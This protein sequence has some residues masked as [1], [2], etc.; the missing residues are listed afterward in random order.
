MQT[1]PVDPQTPFTPQVT[2]PLKPPMPESSPTLVSSPLHAAAD[3]PVATPQFF[4]PPRT[5]SFTAASADDDTAFFE[6]LLEDSDEDEVTS[7]LM[8]SAAKGPA[9]PHPQLVSAPAAFGQGS[10]PGGSMQSFASPPRVPTGPPPFVPPQ[11]QVSEQPSLVSPGPIPFGPVSPPEALQYTQHGGCLR[12]RNTG[13]VKLRVC[14][15]RMPSQARRG[16]SVRG[17]NWWRVAWRGLL[18]PEISPRRA[19]RSQT[20]SCRLQPPPARTTPLGRTA[21]NWNFPT[22]RGEEDV[23]FFAASTSPGAQEQQAPLPSFPA[24]DWQQPSAQPGGHLPSAWPHEPAPPPPVATHS[25]PPDD[26]VSFFNQETPK[27][28]QAPTPQAPN[29]FS[30]GPFSDARP[31]E[32]APP[33]T[34]TG[35]P[36]STWTYPVPSQGG[37]ASFFEP[38]AAIQPAAS[39]LPIPSQPH[40]PNHMGSVQ[41]PPF[42][43]P[44]ATPGAAPG[45]AQ[46]EAWAAYHAPPGPVNVPHAAPGVLGTPASGSNASPGTS[47]A[48]QSAPAAC[49]RRAGRVP[50]AFRGVSR[51]AP[52]STQAV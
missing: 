48:Q 30:N 35:P 28:S 38:A 33:N 26:D 9:A 6:H 14:R 39:T 16:R 20:P 15:G 45:P 36:V 27:G 34:A 50:R 4:S 40:A 3:P 46:G 17:S 49:A 1:P 7:S 37:G 31:Y 19:L 5:V 18:L 11:V 24:V 44:S 29:P 51:A 13:Q 43:P 10:V 12:S 8:S 47:D 22:P 41:G 2:R 32:P 21:L 52:E 23:D 25:F 42:A